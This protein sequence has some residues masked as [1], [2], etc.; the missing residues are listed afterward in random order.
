MASESRVMENAPLIVN[1]AP[2]GL[3]PTRR[4][5]PH[6]PL[7][8]HE[9]ADQVCALAMQGVNMVHLHARDPENGQPTYKKQI[10][11]QIIAGIREKNE[12]LVIGVSTSGRVFTD[13]GQRAD[14]LD[15]NGDLKPDFASLTLGSMNFN[16]HASVNSP[17]VIK[18]LA[19]KMLDC[20]IRPELEVFDLGMINY[21]RYLT[22]KELLKPPFYFNL[23]LG[24]VASAQADM[25]T[26]ALMIRELPPGSVWSLGGIGRFQ[27][28]MN[29]AAISFGGGVRV[30][31]EDN[32]YY[33]DDRRRLASNHE[34]VERV[35]R[36]AAALGRRPYPQRE[37][38]TALTLPSRAAHTGLNS[39][40]MK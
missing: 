38:R 20:G 33:D 28:R 27:L 11:G 8:P 25:L 13:F 17:Q 24:N 30:G 37:L 34:L 15:L 21:A 14:V 39:V 10:Y 5:S 9:I 4:M 35:L 29:A 16:H 19:A 32:L 3:I 31:L 2:T 1:L 22:A 7:T 12:E 6:V 26:T 18:D 23:I 40:A 36:I